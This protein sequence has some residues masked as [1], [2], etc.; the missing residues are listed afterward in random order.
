MASA[1]I[2][3]AEVDFRLTPSE[4]LVLAKALE[5]FRMFWVEEFFATEDLAWHEVLRAQCSTPMAWGEVAVSQLEWVP[6][7]ANRWIDFMRMHISACG[8]LNMA[9]KTRRH[10]R[11]L[12]RS[13]RVAWSG[14]RVAGWSRRQH[15][16]RFRGAEFRLR[17]RRA[18]LGSVAGAFPGCPERKNGMTYSNDLPGL[19]IDIDEKIAAKFAPTTPGTDRGV[20]CYD[21]SPCRP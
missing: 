2:I 14:Q 8:G 19:G 16:H 13:H 1:L 4:G 10:V 17:R 3:C 15:A 12:Q 9:R 21:G 18:V 5:P 7:V 20:R 6:L 11:V